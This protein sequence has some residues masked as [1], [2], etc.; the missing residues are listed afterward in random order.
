MSARCSQCH[1]YN[2]GCPPGL[3]NHKNSSP[4]GPN[5]TMNIQGRH[6]RD[7]ADP[8]NPVC[9]HESKGV[10]C[11]FFTNQDHAAMAYPSDISFE[12]AAAE[13]DVSENN[14]DM[15]HIILLL[16]N[17]KI[18]SDRQFSLLQQQVTAL[19]LDRAP[20]STTAPPSYPTAPPSYPAAPSAPPPPTFSTPATAPHL[21]SS[22]AAS[23]SSH[24]QAGLGHQHN[25]GYQGITMNDLRSNQAM[26]T[27]AN[28]VLANSTLN[29]PPLNPLAGMGVAIGNLNSSGQ[30]QVTS[31]DQLYSATVINK[32]LR[33]YEFAATGQ[34]SY[35]SQLRQDNCNSIS[36]AYGSFKHL[37][38]AKLGLI[39]MSD[40]EFL[41]R[42]RHLKN[43]FE[44]ACLSS[45]LS[46]FT[47]TAW[48][49]ARE[50]DSRV[51]ADI[52]SGAKSWESLSTGLETDAIYCAK[53]TVELKNKAKKTPK[54]LK[55]PKRPKDPKDAKNKTCST[56]NTHRASDGCYWEHHNKGETC[57]FEHFCSWCKTN[58][59]VKEKHKVIQCEHKTE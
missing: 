34:F 48:Q 33:S 1:C 22:A 21:V 32:Q 10:K 36:F 43:V 19:T 4:V 13:N 20:A 53:E 6:Y 46:S 52:E 18:A 7:P 55:D 27:E 16:Q 59:D 2:R 42:L 41:S 11:D 54:D 5:C 30:N 23:L 58:R 57:V 51:I 56:F 17:Q 12:P 14:T 26:V 24:L 40:T 50:Y 44:V 45:N 25:F 31:V 3:P 38:A 35:K 49:V 47:D 8:S 39:P 37:E 15:S 9:D 28:R 29:V